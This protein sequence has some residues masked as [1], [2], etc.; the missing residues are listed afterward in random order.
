VKKETPS[1]YRHYRFWSL[2]IYAYV[3]K[4]CRK[5]VCL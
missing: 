1:S 2:F 4:V 3:Y 5:R